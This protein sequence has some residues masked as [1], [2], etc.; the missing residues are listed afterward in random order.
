MAPTPP[1]TDEEIARIIAIQDEEK[2]NLELYRLLD[3]RKRTYIQARTD[4]LLNSAPYIGSPMDAQVQAAEEFETDFLMPLQNVYG[5]L[6]EKVFQLQFP[7]PTPDLAP[8]MDVPLVGDEPTFGTAIRPQVRMEEDIAERETARSGVESSIDF[9]AIEEAFVEMEGMEPDQA[10]IQ[11][12]A[13][14]RAYEAEKAANPTQQPDDV[15][16]RVI[17]QLEALGTNLEGEG[18]V[19]M[20]EDEQGARR[21]PADPVYQTF[22]RQRDQGQPVPDLTVAQTAYF[23]TIYKDQKANRREELTEEFTGQFDK[24][25]RYNGDEYPYEAFMAM[26]QASSE[27]GGSYEVFD[28]EVTP[29]LAGRRANVATERELPA[30]W[31]ADP[32]KKPKVLADPQAYT[33]LGFF[34]STTPYGGQVETP[35]GWLIRSALIIPNTIAGAGSEY[36]AM[37][38][39][40]AF[41]DTDLDTA[42]KA[43]RPALY[44]DSPVL[45]NIAENRGFTMEMN[46]AA[47]LIDL[48]PTGKF[49]FTAVGFAGDLLDP[50]FG[51]VGGAMK[52]SKTAV[53][54]TKARRA[55]YGG[56]SLMTSMA[57]GSKAG[58]VDGV[59]YFLRDTNMFT[60]PVNLADKA[61]DKATKG[62]RTVAGG[63]ADR[64]GQRLAVGDVRMAMATDLAGSLE[65]RAIARGSEDAAQATT[66]I[67]EAGLSNSAYG[68]AIG[69]N[70]DGVTD[71]EGF[72]RALDDTDKIITAKTGTGRVADDLVNVVDDFD[73]VTKS[74]DDIAAGRDPSRPIPMDELAQNLGALAKRDGAME[75][76]FRGVDDSSYLNIDRV[77]AGPKRMKD[78]VRV[79]GKVN[80][81]PRLRRQFAYDKA[82]G[83]V[84]E[85][86]TNMVGLDDFRMLTPNT[87]V[88]TEETANKILTSV[89]DNTDI[90]IIGKQFADLGA[91]GV[92]VVERMSLK[93][94]ITTSQG[95]KGIQRNAEPAF[96]L[97]GVPT[98]EGKFA[99]DP[100][101]IQFRI[102]K[103]AE[104]LLGYNKITNNTFREV[105]ANL[106]S[107]SGSFI[108]TRNYRQLLHGTIDLVAEGKQVALRAK[109]VGKLPAAE[110]NRLLDPV[111]MRSFARGQLRQW[112]SNFFQGAG[113]T[114]TRAITPTQRQV[115]RNAQ[116]EASNMDTSLRR[117]VA[118]LNKNADEAAKYGVQGTIDDKS[119]AIGVLLVGERQATSAG[120]RVSMGTLRQEE[121]VAD[122]M[123]WYMRTMFYVEKSTESLLD[124]VLGFKKVFE[125]PNKFLNSTGQDLLQESIEAAAKRAVADPTTYW[126]E[127]MKVADDFKQ[128]IITNP[129]NLKPRVRKGSITD[130]FTKNGGKVPAEVQVGSYYWAESQRIMDRSME[131]IFSTDPLM[132]KYTSAMATDKVGGGSLG[133]LATEIGIGPNGVEGLYQEYI[134]RRAARQVVEG[135]GSSR[136]YISMFEDLYDAAVKVGPE[137]IVDNLKMKD[138]RKKIDTYKA[139][140]DNLS[141]QIG[142]TVE[143]VG[144]RNILL[145]GDD[146]GHNLIIRNGLNTNDFGSSY[147]GM[148][149]TI[150]DIT[151]P[152]NSKFFEGVLGR[153]AMDDLK[154]SIDAGKVN[155]FSKYVDTAIRNAGGLRGARDVK[156]LVD[157]V[158]YLMR[159]VNNL[160]YTILLSA[161]TRFHGANILT[162][163]FITYSTVG[164]IPN[165]ARGLQVF[166]EGY[167]MSG[168]NR[169]K[170]ISAPD[171]R[172]YT[173]GEIADGL[174]NAGI[175]SEFGFITDVATQ[176]RIIS[177]AKANGVKNPIGKGGVKEGARA[178]SVKAGQIAQDVI[179]AEDMAWRAGVAIDALESG[180]SFD[181]AM[182]LAR[183]SMFDY[184][185]MTAFEKGL[186]GYAFIFYAFA[187]QNFVTLLRNMMNP[188]GM[189]RIVNV[190]KTERG[191]EAMANTIS[192][193]DMNPDQF[194]PDYVN[195]RVVY[196]KMGSKPSRDVYV[197]GPPIPPIDA[198][199]MLGTLMKQGGLSELI[200][201]QLHPNFAAALDIE[202]FPVSSKEL[203]PEHAAAIALFVGEDPQDIA[204]YF[205]KLVGD[206]VTPI[207]STDVTAINGYKYPLS[208]QQQANY[209][210]LQKWMLN[211]TGFSSFSTD[212]SR[213]FSP[214][215]TVVEDL[216]TF[217]RV[218][219]FGS[220]AMTPMNVARPAK[221]S[222]YD[223]Q[224]RLSAINDRLREIKEEEKKER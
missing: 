5:E 20:L 60:T 157:G 123:N 89:V 23:D 125:N 43:A 103:V 98:A 2:R 40:D 135:R 48:G 160:R 152:D 121:V 83:Y 145:R 189:K 9:A 119:T 222:Q 213:L 136:E 91:E 66:R 127:M 69:R 88:R 55:I 46:E 117:G 138:L 161:R 199:V 169:L 47:D 63:A 177:W 209:K 56:E 112:A 221:V 39:I 131:D 165:G 111:E 14:Q 31:W 196:K 35:V 122:T 155:G 182:N 219:G 84:M 114:E 223:I 81:I 6:P 207:P 158:A 200:Q 113:K 130:V 171:G 74:L 212:Y 201:K 118:R 214:E 107:A 211:F 29:T 175:R 195:A 126:D 108:T 24:Y 203:R 101:T 33:E 149:R 12:R 140:P 167:F 134:K 7:L 197:A 142:L 188:T 170:T 210:L 26:R 187:R 42:R 224:S 18:D 198:M 36:V 92:P 215:G 147:E 133:R 73:A 102:Q 82:L 10:A 11:R 173:Y 176:Q 146:A 52:G 19:E 194:S 94:T 192:G 218:L 79:L 1:R 143:T 183:R 97:S 27:F 100:E 162:A 181:E 191:L 50:S 180:R 3:G 22:V 53:Q 151:S 77:A 34:S 58:A 41:S 25:V 51:L 104:E 70:L 86:A 16:E 72:Q 80:A 186:S 45:L 78:Y 85:N 61:L 76:L 54:M 220:A 28:K 87:W 204:Y 75:N 62:T 68:K 95:Q 139:N 96:D 216:S 115:V 93:E 159:S 64:M 44:E 32:D 144:Y 57:A 59:G 172:M 178:A 166:T 206:K 109:D 17:K 150:D 21:G 184:N 185:D 4:E 120:G 202:G 205:S 154:A 106:G 8:P 67:A 174:I 105:M 99:V 13:I 128:N 38:V 153:D 90:G 137:D 179:M 164:K 49:A 217:E 193:T 71:A 208:K 190:L 163:P 110:A 37:P 129:D 141:T 124:S 116:Q 148:M 168:K 65:A 156:R 30:L 132:N 15:F